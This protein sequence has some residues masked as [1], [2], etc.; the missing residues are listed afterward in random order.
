VARRALESRESLKV[1]ITGAGGYLG[2]LL[3]RE[4]ARRGDTVHA[5]ARDP[6]AVPALPNVSVHGADITRAADIPDTFFERADVV[7]HCAAEILQEPL[8]RAVNV[9]ATREL[10]ARANGRIAHW[11][12]VGSLSVYG[13]PRFGVIDEDTPCEPRSVYAQTKLEGDRVVEQSAGRAFSWTIVR[14]A[15]VI[16]PNMRNR[17]LFALID[18][19]S[20]GRFCFIGQHAA[21]ANYIH[22]ENVVEALLLCAT[23]PEAKGRVY[24]LAQNTTIERLVHAICSELGRTVPRL[25]IPETAARLASQLARFSTS[26]PLTAQRVDALTSRVEYGTTRIERELGYMHRKPLEDAL[27]KMTER[28]KAE[29]A[30]AS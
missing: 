30:S 17:S 12:Q 4:H 15:A 1:S 23:K 9:E 28:W 27:R 5:L 19:V 16:G 20:R 29:R 22:E 18:A 24:N 8:M 25:R 3:A 10:L 11:V 14:P 7:Y 6:A 26:F 13:N 21:V 2:G